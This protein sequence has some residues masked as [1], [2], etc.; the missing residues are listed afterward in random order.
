MSSYRWYHIV[1][2][3]C[4][5]VW[6][7]LFGPRCVRCNCRGAYRQRMMTAYND[8]ESNWTN[9]CDSCME[10]TQDYWADMWLDYYRSR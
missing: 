5:K 3:Y 1:K 9:Q 6:N 4:W 8:E 7:W 2:Y 10:E